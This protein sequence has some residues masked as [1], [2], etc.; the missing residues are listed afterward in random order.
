MTD[1][2]EAFILDQEEDGDGLHGSVQTLDPD[3]VPDADTTLRVLYSSINYKDALAVRD[4]APIIRGDVPIAPGIDLVGRVERSTSDRFRTG[5]LVIGTGWG[6]GE[7]VWGGYTQLAKVDSSKLVPLPEALPAKHAMAIGTAGFTA[8]L[9]VMAL[10]E[11]DATPGDGEI[12]VTG[13]SGGAGSMATAILAALD[14]DVVASTG[15]EDAHGYLKG[16]GASRI[17]HRDELSGGPK[18]PMESGRW[19]GAIDAVGGDTLATII[20]QLKRHASVAS[21]GNAGGHEL[22]TTVFPFILRGVN[23]LGIDSNTCPNARRIVAWERM[24]GILSSDTI[25]SMIHSVVQL[26]RIDEAAQRIL[27]TGVRGRIVVRVG[28]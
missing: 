17:I 10:E 12:L 27:D 22:N 24:A 4:A 6:L 23:L 11:H 3:S 19:A 26:D 2:F 14:F 25:E 9:S 7:N 20:A 5:D 18:R 15:S 21:F 28:G 1:S 16:L 13:A 8:M